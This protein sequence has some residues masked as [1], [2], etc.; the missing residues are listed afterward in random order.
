MAVISDGSVLVGWEAASNLH[1]VTDENPQRQAHAGLIMQR[2]GVAPV[3][4]AAF[5]GHTLAVHLSTYVPSTKRGAG[6]LR[7]GSGSPWQ[8]GCE[9]LVNLSP[10]P[11]PAVRA[12]W[13]PT[14]PITV[15]LAGFEPAAP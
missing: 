7:A 3:D 8:R 6:P 9:T 10:I 15:G 13:P 4:A 2:A 12:E 1:P 11:Q 5:V 14:R